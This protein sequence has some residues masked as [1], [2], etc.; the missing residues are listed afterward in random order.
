MLYIFFFLNHYR[1]GSIVC[2][3]TVAFFNPEVANNPGT[4]APPVE[5]LNS[6]II[7]SVFKD[8]IKNGS[9][10]EATNFEIDTTTFTIEGNL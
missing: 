1:E 7:V 5:N 10:E 6:E 3:F 8:V 9:V 4:E 2:E